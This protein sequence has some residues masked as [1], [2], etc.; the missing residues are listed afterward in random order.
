MVYK[1][2]VMIPPFLSLSWCFLWPL[3][4]PREWVGF[5]IWWR[6]QNEEVKL[7]LHSFQPALNTSPGYRGGS[8]RNNAGHW[9][10]LAVAY[11]GWDMTMLFD[12]MVTREVH[13]IRSSVWWKAASVMRGGI[14]GK[15][16]TLGKDKKINIYIYI[17]PNQV[18]D[19]NMKRQG[20]A[21]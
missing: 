7:E 2:H 10:Y 15:G 21:H 12:E 16:P 3:G 13:I 19:Q 11:N 18:Q 4:L 17:H 9:Y 8:L 6:R 14:C 20:V 1:L 5:N